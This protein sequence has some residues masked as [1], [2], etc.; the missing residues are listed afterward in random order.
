MTSRARTAIL[1]SGRGSNM[2]AIARA[3]QDPEWP[4]D[5]VLVAANKAKAAGLEAARAM[6]IEAIALPHRDYPSR[7]AFDMALSAALKARGIEL[8]VLA[9]FMRILTP[10]FIRDWEGRIVNIHPSLLPKYQGLDTH[11]RAIEAGDAE[12]G[13]TVHLVT[14]KLDDGPILAQ[15]RVPIL[16]D[17][18]PDSLSGRVLAEEHR[19]YPPAVAALAARLVAARA[20]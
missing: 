2:L 1:I 14:E 5:V 4:A 3:A 12:A 9:G 13:C 6:G 11:A 18:T 7:E 15:A 17:D 19:I 20:A 16:P 10:A 8:V